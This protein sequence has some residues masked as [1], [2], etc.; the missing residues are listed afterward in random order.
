MNAALRFTYQ[1]Y[2]QLSED[3][4]YEIVDGDLYSF[5]ASTPYHQKVSR[6]LAFQLHQ[7]VDE[8]DLGETLKGPCDVLLSETDVVQPDILFIGKDRLSIIKEPNI[9]GAP[10]LVVEILS[11]ASE[12]R[13]RGA[14]QKLYARAGVTES[15]I[16]DPTA[17]TVEVLSLGET[18]YQRVNLFN[19]SDTLRSLL[20]PVLTISLS[21]IF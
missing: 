5:P 13:D 21:D 6:N 3:Q 11:P 18:G 19:H 14:K 20:F 4:R 17:K 8:M 7:F 15:W 10:D 9:H 2:L 16:A 1:D 12:K